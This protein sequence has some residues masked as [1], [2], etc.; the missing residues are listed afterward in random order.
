MKKIKISR[1]RIETLAKIIENFN[2]LRPYFLHYKT[3]S[4]EK[5]KI[6]FRILAK[7]TKKLASLLQLSTLPVSTMSV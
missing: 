4:T 3:D 2:Y 1:K 6:Y 7:L 5:S